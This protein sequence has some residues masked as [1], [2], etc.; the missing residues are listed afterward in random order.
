MMRHPKPLLFPVFILLFFLVL[1]GFGQECFLSSGPDTF[2]F[3][4]FLMNYLPGGFFYPSFIENYAPDVTFLIEES[5]AFSLIDNPKVYFEGDSFINFNWQYNGMNINSALNNGSPAL[6]LPFSSVTAY[7][8]QGESPGSRNYGLDFISRVPGKD[9]SRVLFSTVYTD[10][11]TY[12][13]WLTF[14]VEGHA[15]TRD[16]RLYNTRRKILNNY[17][18]DYIFSKKFKNSE[19]TVSMN[20]FD[21]KRKFND[22]KE[23]DTTYEE[24][25][26]LFLTNTRYRRELTGGAL[27]I[28]AAFNASDRSAFNAETG[29]LPEENAAKKKNSFLTGLFL[30]KKKFDF[31]FSF[32]YE[33]EKLTPAAENF[34]KELQDND[35]DGFFPWSRL[36]E[37]SAAVFNSGLDIPLKYDFLGKTLKINTF[38]EARHSILRGS[39]EIHG[40]NPLFFGNT[41]YL[42]V[43]WQ[44]GSDYTNSNTN[45]KIGM[46]ISWDFSRNLSLLSKLFV[47]YNRLGFENAG[48]NLTFLLPG[49]DVG[50]QLFKNKKTRILLAYGVTPYDI[51]E[52]INFTLESNRPYGTINYW[53][54]RNRD[55]TFQPGEQ[56]EPYGYTGAAYHRVDEDISAPVKQRLLLTV[57]SKIS[58]N[59]IFNVKGIL[60]KVKNNFTFRFA[61]EYGFYEQHNDQDIYFFNRPFENYLLTNYDYRKDPLYAQ[62]LLNFIGG[63][64]EKWFFNFSFLAHM[65]LGVTAFGNG[66]GSNDIGIINESMANPNSWIN[67]FGRVDGDR[68]FVAKLYF[69]F[70]LSKNLFLGTGL[71]YRD[72]NP[73]AF[74]NSLYAHDQW[75]LYYATIKAEDEKGVK[76]GPREDYVGDISIKLNYRFKLFNNDAL[77][78]LSVFNL[79]DLGHELSEYVFSGGSRDAMELN[80]PRSLRLTLSMG[81]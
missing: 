58:K 6:L 80:M 45:M 17:F 79:L 61:E 81:F 30:K 42:V 51:R 60:K 5:N 24:T 36:G 70:Y 32:Q 15:S 76:G 77:L 4:G 14:M 48:N 3:D 26:R 35:G 37:F 16:D 11:G 43:S 46:N 69:G 38:L 20:Y 13:P 72:G 23:F 9:I 73:F 63:K 29:S 21:I 25:G 49:Y 39:E 41:P 78:S 53:D 22:F 54:D 44:P 71:K 34:S 33:S 67:G 1:T 47:Q 7:K 10:L 27:E 55:L 62:L 56:G 8:L 65:G 57:S 18:I 59:F 28:V 19:V 52:N 50:V 64:K 74:I 31:N 2:I 66:P 68:A 40:H 12:T 75:V